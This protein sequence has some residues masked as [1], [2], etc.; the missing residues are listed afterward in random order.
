[1]RLKTVKKS[2]PP[3]IYGGGLLFILGRGETVVSMSQQGL[4]LFDSFLIERNK[5]MMPFGK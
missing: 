4:S 3:L 1:M 2:N 5:G